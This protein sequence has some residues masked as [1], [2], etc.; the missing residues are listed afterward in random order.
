MYTYFP[1]LF[2]LLHP[3]Q[4]FLTDD[5]TFMPRICVLHGS[6]AAAVIL[7]VEDARCVVVVVVVAA[8]L[9]MALFLHTPARER[10]LYAFVNGED[11]RRVG[12]GLRRRRRS[13]EGSIVRSPSNKM[14]Q[15][16]ETKRIRLI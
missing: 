2:T 12:V 10:M 8:V 15:D 13:S 6:S 5:R 14:D 9:V 1:F 3:S 16:E 11:G 7:F 4:S